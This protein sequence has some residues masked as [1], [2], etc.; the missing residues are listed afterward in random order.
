MIYLCCD[1]KSSVSLRQPL[2]AHRM[3]KLRG[4]LGFPCSNRGG[5]P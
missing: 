4:R 1:L 3:Y 2:P 5:E